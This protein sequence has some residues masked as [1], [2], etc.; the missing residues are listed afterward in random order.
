[1]SVLDKGKGRGR[2]RQEE[3]WGTEELA[4]NPYL[5]NHQVEGGNHLLCSALSTE[6]WIS[7]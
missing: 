7:L 4:S 5:R 6:I 3:N 2:K 1:M